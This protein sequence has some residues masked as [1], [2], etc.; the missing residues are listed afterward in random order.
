VTGD[1]H[2]RAALPQPVDGRE[3]GR[4]AQIVVHDAVA[5]R[6][7]EVDAHECPLPLLQGQVFQPG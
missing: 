2:D 4:D 7:V 3:R 1:D 6:H 5:Q